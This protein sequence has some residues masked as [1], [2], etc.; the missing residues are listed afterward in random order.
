M[1]L[2]GLQL[3]RLADAIMFIITLSLPRVI[4]SY[5]ELNSKNTAV[6]PRLFPAV[7]SLSTPASYVSP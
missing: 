7:A 4:A 3:Q 6:A 5:S 1:Q 2:P